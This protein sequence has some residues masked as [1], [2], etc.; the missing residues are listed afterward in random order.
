MGAI[1]SSAL[2]SHAQVTVTATAGVT[3][4]TV[5]TQLRLA[6]NAINA[7]THQGAVT[8]SITANTT[9]TAAAQLNAPPVPGYTSVLVKPAIGASPVISGNFNNNGIVYLRGATNVTIDGSNTVGGT[10]RDLTIRNTLAGGAVAAIRFG[11]PSA[12]LG[13]SNNTVKNCIL[14][15]ANNV[16][17]MAI[18]S[19][20]GTTIFAIGEA[21]NSNNTIEN[22]QMT[23]A[24]LGFYAYG[25]AGQDANWT[26]RGNDI[27]GTGF[28]GIHVNN[29]NGT[30][31]TKNNINNVS[32][33]GGSPVSGIVLSFEADNTTIT[34]NK[35][36]NINNTVANG[37]YGMYFDVNT[38]SSNINVYNNFVLNCFGAAAGTAWQNA[39]GMYLDLG[40]GFN[41]YHN[42]VQI[43]TNSP[44]GAVNSAICFDPFLGLG[45]ITNAGVNLRNN[46]FGNNQT[47]NTRYGILSTGTAA[48]F[49]AIDYNDYVATSGNLGFIGGAARTTLA[50]IQ[51]GFGGNVNSINAA[52]TYVSPTDLHLQV[53]PANEALNIGIPIASPSITTD[54]DNNNRV[55]TT[56]TVGAHEMYNKI[57]YTALANTCSDGVITLNPV[58]IE[59]SLGINTTGPNMP[60]I[61]FRKGAGAWFSA[62]GTFVSGTANNSIWTFT[63][64]PATMGGVTGGDVISYYVIAQTSTAPIGAFSNPF[65]G[66]V[67]TGVNTVTTPPT[68]PNTYT[69]NTVFINGLTTSQFACSSTSGINVPY[70]YTGTTGAPNEYTLTWSPTGGPSDVP[71]FASFPA[72]PLNVFVPAGATPGPYAGTLTVRN[73]STTC[74]RTYNITLTINPTPAITGPTTVCIGSSNPYGTSIAGGTWT[75]SNP[76]VGTISTS[77]ILSALTSGT[78]TIGYTTAA[79][80]TANTVV[81]VST[82]PAPITGAAA[83]CSGDNITL[84]TTSTGGVW[85]SGSTAI[86]VVDPG[87]GVVSTGIAG[88]AVISYTIAGCTPSTTIVTVYPAP[89]PITGNA[90]VCEG[91]TTTLTTPSVGGT[92]VS[93][94]A[95]IATVGSSTGLVTG[96]NPGT[97]VISYVFASTGCARTYTINI[98]ALPDTITGPIPALICQGQTVTLSNGTTGGTWGS[99]TPGVI[100]VNPTTGNAT[101]NGASGTATITYT[102]GFSCYVTKVYTVSTAPTAISGPTTVMCTGNSLALGNGTPGG[103]WTSSNP[104]VGSVSSTGVVY[105]VN[106]GTVTI[107]YFTASC[108]AV[109]Y[110]VTVNQTPK[111]ITGG[112]TICDGSSMTTITDSSAGGIFTLSGPGASISPTT[113]SGGIAQSTITGLT[114]GGT[115]VATYTM[116]NACFVNAPIIVDT[117]P[118]PITGVDSICMGITT[119][120]STPST[121][122]IWSSSNSAIA[123]VVASTG[124]VTGV[125]YGIATITYAAVSGCARTR[126]ILIR[127]P[128]P[129]SVSITRT[130][131]IDTL[132][133]GTPVTFTAHTINGGITPAFE[134]QRF[135]V[136]VFSGDSVFTYTPIHGD[137]ISVY[138]MYSPDVCSW[139]APAYAN[140]P[141]NVYPN[142]APVVTISTTSATTITFLGQVVTFFAEVSTSGGSHTYQWYVDGDAIPGATSATYARAIY[143]NDS[144]FCMV[145]GTP[146]CETGSIGTSN[147]IVIYGDYLNVTQVDQNNN[148]SLFPNPN[149]GTFSL[150]GTVGIENK[151]VKVEVINVLGQTVHTQNVAVINGAVNAHIVPAST[152]APGTYILR[153]NAASESNI[154]HFVVSQ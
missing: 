122:G 141:I 131:N 17:G 101:A 66:L 10:T 111:P 50:Q 115:Y 49:S 38:T 121:G 60:R 65:P 5:Y 106:S 8:V 30:V 124:E 105:G 2:Q 150:T 45:G 103:T 64:N 4:P 126:P 9:E 36:S 55:T 76:A 46:I 41:I 44:A 139:P 89:A 22:N 32:I 70:A 102:T 7:G 99:S 62:P 127:T 93:G 129:A 20:S 73:N 77:G 21:P 29:G 3:G 67:A 23:N 116:P 18:T 134:W 40:N 123:S 136:T 28:A 68:T 108:P 75:S 125:S 13:T 114:V 25:P 47:I 82:P 33:N 15:C 96:V 51:A 48:M 6:F 113:V 153:V 86:A 109:T 149:N 39:H 53:A 12:V 56:P 151:S 118:A 144:V 52:P 31:I 63:I 58:T 110:N 107:G 11:S 72:S 37:T 83:V 98:S 130:P 71:V 128:L 94:S 16:S 84:S 137:V 42:T 112:I 19:G 85:T 104:A 145:N 152:F 91:D 143:D 27:S 81:T 24:Q 54:I 119:M 88:T 97:A 35:I 61:Y 87:T 79:G 59:S 78:T 142:V 138:M 132:C 146:P 80:C 74:S 120:M 95:T 34:D 140:I 90:Y 135:G 1:L 133:A 147:S 148:M 43:T 100:S 92:W 57:T 117:L 14:S 26:I 69:V 154:F